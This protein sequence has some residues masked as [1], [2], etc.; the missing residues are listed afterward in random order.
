[1]MVKS[2]GRWYLSRRGEHL[3][4]RKM[5][6]VLE[7]LS[8]SEGVG[9]GGRSWVEERYHCSTCL[10]LVEFVPLPLRTVVLRPFGRG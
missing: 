7:V 4:T 5:L 1:M 10:V 2:G 3:L 6:L 9:I 8:E